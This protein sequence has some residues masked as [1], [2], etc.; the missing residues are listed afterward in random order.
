MESKSASDISKEAFSEVVQAISRDMPLVMHGNGDV[1]PF[2][3]NEESVRLLS[4]LTANYIGSLVETAVDAHAMLNDGPRALPPPPLPRNSRRNTVPIPS[5]PTEKSET[6]RKRRRATDEFWDEP[7]QEPKIKN[8]PKPKNNEKVQTFEGVPID[9]WVG[10]AGVDFWESSRARKVH[11][12][13]PAAI[14]S[15][16]FVFPVCHDSGLYGKVSD[17]QMARGTIAPILLDDTVRDEVAKE[18]ALHGAG[19]LRGR[20]KKSTNEDELDEPEETDSEDEDRATW[21][22]T[23]SLLPVHMT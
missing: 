21:P 22:G 18:V 14:S 10:V 5:P 12:S 8:K 15:Q 20:E 9:E 4:E 2:A 13:A 1:Q 6:N 19:A 17:I 3:V 16:C 7:L 11:V 23:N